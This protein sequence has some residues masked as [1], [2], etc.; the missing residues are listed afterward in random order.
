MSAHFELSV[1]QIKKATGFLQRLPSNT[2]ESDSSLLAQTETL[3]SDGGRSRVAAVMAGEDVTE[4]TAA[5][6][7]PVSSLHS[8]I[9][10]F[11]IMVHSLFISLVC[12]FKAPA[13]FVAD[14][15]Q[16]QLQFTKLQL[17][18]IILLH[19]SSQICLVL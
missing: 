6:K 9:C 12:F 10:F 17:P 4:A 16:V 19:S 13:L 1:T 18:S 7:C 11:L 5:E 15:N 8:A 14:L 3:L 2:C